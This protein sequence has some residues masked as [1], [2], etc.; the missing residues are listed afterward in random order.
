MDVGF[1]RAALALPLPLLDYICLCAD[2]E[3]DDALS[4]I[5]QAQLDRFQA[6]LLKTAAGGG[7]HEGDIEIL[8]DGPR[9]V[10]N[11]RVPGAECW[12]DEAHHSG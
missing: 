12:R 8:R 1:T 7:N 2:G 10:L 5:H 6:D 9:E 4:P 11:N 3:L